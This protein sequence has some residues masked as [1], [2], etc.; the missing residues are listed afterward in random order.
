M[1]QRSPHKP[2]ER[3][4]QLPQQPP[5]HQQWLIEQ[6]TD[7]LETLLSGVAAVST[8]AEEMARDLPGEL[9]RP[10]NRELRLRGNRFQ[11]RR[12]QASRRA[13]ACLAARSSSSRS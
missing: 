4:Q 3:R 7:L 2:Q 11:V 10:V 13:S 1:V 8:S 12:P 6:W 5:T 9:V